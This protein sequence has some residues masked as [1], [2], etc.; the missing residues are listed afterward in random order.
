MENNMIDLYKQLSIDNQRN[1][2][3]SLILKIDKL[4]DELMFK[5]N[6]PKFGQVKNF[7]ISSNDGMSEND[8]LAFFYEDLWIIKNKILALLIE[9]D[10][11]ENKNE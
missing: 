9:K 11:L 4:L 2:L 8:I 5:S 10:R 7:D 1:E 3:S 6:L